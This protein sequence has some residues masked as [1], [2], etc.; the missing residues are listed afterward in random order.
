[1][2]DYSFMKSGLGNND[3]NFSP[4]NIEVMLSLFTSN[5]LINASKYVELDE[6]KC[7][8]T[9]DIHY[10]M[11][12]EVFE[13]LKRKNLM[14]EFDQMKEEYNTYLE[15]ESDDENE[16]DEYIE[17]DPEKIEPFRKIDST[18]INNTE[19]KNFVEKMNNYFDNWPKWI[20]ETPLE[21]IL[22]TAINKYYEL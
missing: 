2:T 10:G 18:K 15:E 14:N 22:Q 7:V 19:D 12:Y 16:F 13:F 21:K 9:T 6:R 17:E 11:I 20:P 3:N 4:D 5:A 1:M 8:T